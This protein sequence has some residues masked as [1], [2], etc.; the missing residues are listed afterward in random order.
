VAGQR[1]HSRYL[2]LLIISVVS[3]C[4]VVGVLGFTR[5]RRGVEELSRANARNTLTLVEEVVESTGGNLTP[6]TTWRTDGGSVR[7]LSLSEVRSEFG[8]VGNLASL[9]EFSTVGRTEAG[10]QL[11]VARSIGE[12]PIVLIAEVSLAP[13]DRLLGDVL[14]AFTV[15]ALLL[16]LSATAF[17]VAAD[18]SIGAA[19]NRLETTV[20]RFA[21]GDL[22]HRV[23]LPE[24][25]G[26]SSLAG[27]LNDMAGL[28]QAT[29]GRITRRRNELEGILSSMV[30]GVIVL[31]TAKRISAINA[32]AA[33]LFNVDIEGAQGEPLIAFL[34]NSEVE[35][36]ADDTLASEEPTERTITIFDIQP[37]HIQ[38]HG[39]VLRGEVGKVI[40]ALIVMSDVTRIRR[41]ETVRREFVANVSHELRTPITSILGFVETLREG[42]MEDPDRARRFLEIIHSHA[43]RLNLIIEDLL[44]LSRLESY[45]ATV[46]MQR[47]EIHEIINSTKLSVAPAAAQK[48]IS[49]ED[50]Y[51]GP[52]EV[53]A[54]ATLL[55]QA[56]KNLMDNAVKYSPENT[57][58]RLS[59]RNRDGFLTVE[60]SDSG[61][62]IP[63][64]DLPRIFERFYRVDRA[65]SRDLGGTGL[66]LA[67]VKHIAIAHRG[68]VNVE[69][70]PG[71]GSTFLFSIP[72][73]SE[74]P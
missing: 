53:T 18:R 58:V 69:S 70:T 26:L 56:I 35:A 62:G 44:S 16:A 15:A 31:D 57:A 51:S 71:K 3:I 6:G 29:L 74:A 50:S 1:F 2:L 55:E 25:P 38:L 7:V 65:R 24:S 68:T 19:V 30:E 54:N 66:G 32:S 21:A 11:V 23:R 4:L 72:Q 10:R 28:F 13:G 40:G 41:L 49:I 14:G 48:N 12:T 73:D 47:C 33:R 63:A 39:T 36:F 22:G 52:T 46:P 37:V 60:I 67:I 42:A 59:V 34:R 5:L 8:F 61:V 64:A 43:N 45:D 9:M 27:A 17:A 20:R